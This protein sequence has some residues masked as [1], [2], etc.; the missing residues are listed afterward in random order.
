MPTGTNLIE[1]FSHY[2]GD[3]I[4]QGLLAGPNGA[5][6]ALGNVGWIFTSFGVVF[7]LWG[8]VLR[9]QAAGAG[10][11]M[12]EIAKTWVLF[13]AILGGPFM[14]QTAMERADT[15][16]ATTIG[17]P[18][19]L[20]AACVK[21]AYG[22]PDP[23]GLLG[24]ASAAPAAATAS[25]PAGSSVGQ[26]VE[27]LVAGSWKAGLGVVGLVGDTMRLGSVMTAAFSTAFR[28]GALV[29][30]FIPVFFLMLASSAI[31]WFMDQLRFFMAIVGTMML[32]LFMGMLSL[33]AGHPNR[34]AAHAYIMNLVSVALW[35]VAW[36]L[37]HTGTIV[38]FDALISLLAG[39][40]RLPALSQFLQW[41]AVSSS[42]AATAAQVQAG[43]VGLSSLL[44]GSL[45][46]MLALDVGAIGFAL[47]V[48]SVSIAGPV[49]LHRCLTTGAL[50]MSQALATTGQYARQGISLAAPVV[51]P[52][53]RPTLASR[54]SAEGK[55]SSQTPPADPL[56]G[57]QNK[58]PKTGLTL[59]GN[60]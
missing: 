2:S 51:F 58:S 48:F 45:S 9:A 4:F 44:E 40:C 32:P 36:T 19:A 23:L 25:T 22:L 53:G 46:S 30:T 47:W 50:F 5:A 35:P 41:S 37:G 52:T 31:I 28:A 54:S 57:T 39:T 33:P 20:A 1:V 60:A 13:G 42:T 26:A 55:Q 14:M 16:Y 7:L 8:F 17:G 24:Q 29:L 10:D 3:V 43:D 11:R 6:G 56:A 38:L 12:G 27:G 18:A 49:L 21:A 15:L 59:G 34:Q